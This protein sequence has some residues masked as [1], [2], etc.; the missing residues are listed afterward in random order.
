MSF[1]I[2]SE[3]SVDDAWRTF[4]R[5]TKILMLFVLCQRLEMYTSIP[6]FTPM[7]KKTETFAAR[8]R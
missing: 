5:V 7:G 6:L 2:L 8:E 3:R 1:L 4:C